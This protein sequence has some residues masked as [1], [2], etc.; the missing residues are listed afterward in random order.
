MGDKKT[1]G[2]RGEGGR[3]VVDGEGETGPWDVLKKKTG[4]CPCV[5]RLFEVEVMRLIHTLIPLQ[6][7]LHCVAVWL[8][9]WLDR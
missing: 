9:S 8:A 6:T 3:A 5:I 7:G 2:E 4:C 1:R